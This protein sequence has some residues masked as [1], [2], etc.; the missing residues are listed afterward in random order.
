M[1]FLEIAKKRI[2]NI[3]YNNVFIIAE[4]TKN[5]ESLNYCTFVCNKV[6][7]Q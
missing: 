2:E 6:F 5:A 7:K 1:K 4:N 3:K